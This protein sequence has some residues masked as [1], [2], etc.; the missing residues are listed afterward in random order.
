[1]NF[2][3]YSKEIQSYILKWWN[4]FLYVTIFLIR[5]TSD[6]KLKFENSKLLNILL[7]LKS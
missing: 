5:G 1:M 4:S 2:G 6:F 7:I 3:I